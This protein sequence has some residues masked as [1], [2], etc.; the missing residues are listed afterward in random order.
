[1]A[2]AFLVPCARSNGEEH[3]GEFLAVAP[4]GHQISGQAAA[5]MK[6]SRFDEWLTFRT[7]MKT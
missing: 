6:N 2:I 4:G 3:L 5:R 7:I 1:M